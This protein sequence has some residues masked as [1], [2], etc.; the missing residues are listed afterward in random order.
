[1]RVFIKLH[2]SISIVL[3]ANYTFVKETDLGWVLA[4]S[5]E[6]SWAAIGPGRTA[7][8]LVNYLSEFLVCMCI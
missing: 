7:E 2:T 8:L 1:M 4:I 3:K 6:F 5:L